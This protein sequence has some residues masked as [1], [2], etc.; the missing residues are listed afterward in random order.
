MLSWIKQYFRG[1]SCFVKRIRVNLPMCPQDQEKFSGT[2]WFKIFTLS[3]VVTKVTWPYVLLFHQ[4]TYKT[5]SYERCCQSNYL[6]W[7]QCR[8]VIFYWVG[9]KT[10]FTTW[11]QNTYHY[12][13]RSV[14]WNRLEAMHKSEPRV[15]GPF[16]APSG[17]Q[18]CAIRAPRKSKGSKNLGNS[19]QHK[20]FFF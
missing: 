6:C 14:T 7:Y 10:K 9:V 18:T 19:L 17:S 4:N 3:K 11:H 15:W 8:I 16:K 1:D 2:G 12:H 20:N 13:D 5:S